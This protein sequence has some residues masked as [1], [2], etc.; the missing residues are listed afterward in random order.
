MALYCAACQM[1]NVYVLQEGCGSFEENPW[2][3]SLMFYGYRDRE[4]LQPDDNDI[5]L[6]PSIIEKVLLPKLTGILIYCRFKTPW[7]MSSPELSPLTLLKDF[8]RLVIYALQRSS[9]VLMEM[10]RLK[11]SYQKLSRKI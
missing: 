2:F 11:H 10:M 5:K 6:I 9:C 7:I 8:I 1:N 3:E 4:E